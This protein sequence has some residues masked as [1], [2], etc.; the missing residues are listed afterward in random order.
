MSEQFAGW[1]ILFRQ[2]LKRDWKKIILWV[3]GLS[4][5]CGGFIPAF[6]EIAKGQ[7]LIGMFET[8]KNPAMISMVGPTP[9]KEAS[10]YTV[11]AM[12][13]HEMLLFCGVFA[14]ILSGL[15][16]I[17]HTRKEEDLGLVEL[18]RSFRVGRLA[19]SLAVV[20]ETITINLLLV[21]VTSSMMMSFNI[22]GIDWEGSLLFSISIGMA[23]VI[24]AV[25]ALVFAQLMPTSAGANGGM[26]SV[27]G[28]LYILRAGTDVSNLDFSRYNPMSWM[29][30]TYPFTENNWWFILVAFGFVIVLFLVGL[31]LE[32]F[33]DMGAG[34]L[35]ERLGRAEAKSSLLSVRGLLV[36][37][38]R[39]TIISW[40]VGYVIMGAV[41]GSIYGDM[42]TFLSSNELIEQMFRQSGVSI[43]ESFTATIMSVLILLVIIL[44]VLLVN[45]LFAEETKLR[46]S[47]IFATKVTRGQ[48]FWTTIGLA[49]VTG[50]VGILLTTGGLGASALA[51][52]D[53]EAQL[54]FIDFIAAGFNFL[55]VILFFVGL[56]A[57]FLG[58]LPKWNKVVYVYLFYTFMLSYFGGILDLP[59]WFSK[60][61]ILNWI[62]TM[63]TESFDLTV[64]ISISLIGCL[65]M[66]IGF[67]GYHKRDLLE[68]E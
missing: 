17:G 65:L 53:G 64:F 16:V 15:H 66:I 12:Y 54:T 1:T 31:L 47:Q 51:S 10:D 5:F 42:N 34:Y 21:I 35:P 61:A 20:K 11:G 18:V 29:Y 9:V 44:P 22:E 59:E 19:N 39:G 41:Y 60:T 40:L 24:G 48:L 30:L 13:A 50:M 23:G 49:I 52:V 33:R 46:F 3:I 27:I 32:N 38:S 28:L 14:M 26:L 7:G 36:Q 67:Y 63:P 37:I 68:G 58:W 25:I 45:K 56:A 43:E 2:Y 4:I 8:L 62:P 55:P 57:V 6:E